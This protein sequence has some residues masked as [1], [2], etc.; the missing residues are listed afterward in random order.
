MDRCVNLD[1]LEVYCLES[2]KDYPHDVEFFMRRGV[3]VVARPYGTRVYAEMFT[4]Y[5]D[6]HEPAIEVRRNPISAK[7]DGSP[8][9]LN[10]MACHIRLVNRSCYRQDAVDFLRSFLF[11]Y[12]FEFQRISRVDIC[13]DFERFDKGDE[14]AAF[15]R[16]YMSGRYSKINQ[17]TIHAHGKDTWEQRVWNS[18]S[19]GAPKSMVSTKFYCKSLELKESRDKPYIRQAWALA[20]LVDDF[21]TLTKRKADGTI[22]KPD[23]W[24]VEFSIRSSVKGWVVTEDYHSHKKKLISMRNTLSCYQT[25]PQMLDI[26]ASLSHRYFYFVKY[27]NGVRKDRCEQKILFDFTQQNDFYNIERPATSRQPENDL[28]KLRIRL[29]S[30]LH[31]C[32]DPDMASAV[33]SLLDLIYEQR[34][35]FSAAIPHDAHEVELLRRL[36]AYRLNNDVNEPVAVS[37]EQTKALIALERAIWSDNEAVQ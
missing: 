19:W 28:E 21:Q 9:V 18:V 2:C 32:I 26:F 8:S 4:I 7:R 31:H 5:D 34:L 1:W 6:A 10:P 22:Y 17:A 16:R 27:Q 29:E 33:H 12:E 37:L 13:L 25:K 11:K 23:I 35:R 14:P 24:R 36:I 20:H 3:E 15:M 30:Y